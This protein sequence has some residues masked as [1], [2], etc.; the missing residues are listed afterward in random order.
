MNTLHCY[1]RAPAE[2]GCEP[3][4]AREL[5]VTIKQVNE[6][7]Y[8]TLMYRRPCQRGSRH[9]EHR[10][11]I[12]DDLFNSVE[13]QDVLAMLHT[14]PEEMVRPVWNVPISKHHRQT[15]HR[16]LVVTWRL[17]QKAKAKSGWNSQKNVPERSP[18]I[19]FFSQKKKRKI[20]PCAAVF[21]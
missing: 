15:P 12:R 4:G 2:T 11:R 1:R 17:F 6:V 13:Q 10:L 16:R 21:W 8:R 14:T 20:F 7:K 3:C 5:A 18:K 19:L 9:E